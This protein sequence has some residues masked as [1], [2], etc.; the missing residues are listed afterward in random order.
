MVFIFTSTSLQR[1]NEIRLFY[2][3]EECSSMNRP[4]QWFWTPFNFETLSKSLWRYDIL[5]Q[6]HTCTHRKLSSVTVKVSLFGF[7]DI[8]SL[9]LLNPSIFYASI[10]VGYSLY[11]DWVIEGN[12]ISSFRKIFSSLGVKTCYKIPW[13]KRMRMWR[14]NFLDN[15]SF[16]DVFRLHRKHFGNFIFI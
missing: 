8:N 16:L 3:V 12:R 14:K 6:T 9:I 13:T 7:D 11:F 15:R 4:T 5:N 2:I 1:I 10:P